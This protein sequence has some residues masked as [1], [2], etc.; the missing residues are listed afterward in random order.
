MTTVGRVSEVQLGKMLQPKPESHGDSEVHYLRAGSLEELTSEEPLRKMWASPNERASYSV[1]SGDLIVAE[2]GDVGRSEFVPKVPADTII[3]NSLHRVRPR[4]GDVRFLKYALDS[5]YY[6]GWL[7]VICNKA[8]F[9]HLT[10]EKLSSLSIPWPPLAEQGAIADYLDA[11]TARIDALIEKK[12]GLSALLHRRVVSLVDVRIRSLLATEAPARVQRVVEEVD[13]RLGHREPPELLV[14]SI[15]DGVLP[16]H[17]FTEDLPRA[18]E[19][20]EY[21]MCREGD[22][23]LNRMR[24]F[25]GGVGRAPCDGIASPDYTVLRPLHNIDG[26]YL[27]HISRSSWFVGEMTSRL[28]GIGGSDQ[29]NVRTPRINFSDLKL[30]QIP[31]PSLQ[32]QRLLVGELENDLQLTRLTAQKLERQVELLTERRQALITAAVTGETEIQEAKA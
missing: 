18:D 27:H 23:I 3:Q 11:E 25:Q 17:E 32:D 26:H 14:V 15:H 4:D 10:R 21:K 1:R 5:I 7:D 28:R 22:L 31:L 29:G 16:R 8:T 13:E 6:S 19:L 20:T 9:G 24:A 12:K 30:I 2:G